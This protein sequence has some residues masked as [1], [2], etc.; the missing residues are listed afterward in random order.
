M[1]HISIPHKNNV[2]YMYNA[3]LDN[4]IELPRVQSFPEVIK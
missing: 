4:N 2:V 1:K 3:V